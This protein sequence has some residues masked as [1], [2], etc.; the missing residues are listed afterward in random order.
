MPP[1][2]SG[3]ADYAEALVEALRPLAALE[4]IAAT[5]AV[6][7][8][9]AYDAIVYQLGNNADHAFVYEMA[10]RY[11]GVVV[12]HEANLHHL[13]TDL[14]IRRQDWDGYLREVEFDGGPAALAFA[15]RVRRRE[16]G[17]D[18]H[19]VPMLRR[20]L[21]CAKGLIVHSRF[22]LE[23]ARTAGFQGPAAVIPHGAW[24][25]AVSGWP[26]RSRLGIV[27]P[28]QPLVGIFGHLKPYKRV[29]ESMRVFRRLIR[30]EPRAKLILVGEP[31][32][33][34]DLERHIANFGLTAHARLLGRTGI[35]DFV[36]YLAASDI[37]LNLRYPTVGETSGTL[38]RALG[39][40]RAV[41]VSNVGAFAEYPDDVCLKAPVDTSEEDTLFE[42]LQLL[43]ARRDLRL[44]LGARAREW[45]AR[46]CSWPVVAERY[47]AFLRGE[48]AVAPAEPCPSPTAAA[49]WT[50]TPTASA[51]AQVSAATEPEPPAARAAPASDRILCWI[52]DDPGAAAYART[53]LTRLEKT[54]D[55]TP[56]GCATDA[57]LEM[58]TYLQLAPA[59][60]YELGYGTVRGCYYGPAGV[61]EDKT[62]RS[63]TG[64]TFSCAVDLFD[65]E[66]DRF[67]YADASFA[68]VLC[69]ELIEHLVR[70]PMHLMA[71][72][73]RILRLGGHLVL[74]TPN[75]ASCRS[76][77][78]IL[79][80]YHPGLYPAYL[81]PAALAKGE[82]RHHREYTAREV[83]RLLSDAGFEVTRLETGPYE[84]QREAEFDWVRAIIER[85]GFDAALRGDCIY[86][87]GRKC[88]PL[89]ERYPS[90]LY[91]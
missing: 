28:E 22:V 76:L 53:H 7:H 42:Y 37:V 80:G 79:E 6:F 59:L 31:H 33:S 41:I 91:S 27:D 69:G 1:A 54:L 19:G 45:V 13:I 10:L 71:E 58:G 17:P 18:Y 66:S 75:I 34:L 8:P 81:K 83:Y 32:E 21:S 89:R 61:T 50:A 82:S 16:V 15:H 46:E 20:V 40:G 51:P 64:E 47:L 63:L 36:G 44:A 84:A 65:A 35:E 2:R 86:A 9:S 52:G 11:P 62:I 56:P 14:T 39:L 30:V 25:P 78:A 60:Q 23:R 48:Q 74:T 67:P 24:M 43:C 3:I 68:T 77:A 38:Q 70:D 49:A 72:V 55:V 26:L 4:V 85:Y 5:P 88:G 73:N 12:L 90:W 57:V 87:V 29:V